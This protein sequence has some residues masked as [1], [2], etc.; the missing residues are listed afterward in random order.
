[1]TFTDPTANLIL[2]MDGMK[3][4]VPNDTVNSHS[5]QMQINPLLF[6]NIDQK[7]VT[8]ILLVFKLL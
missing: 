3:G 7:L 4:S 8:F 1:M 5:I 2:P 6:D